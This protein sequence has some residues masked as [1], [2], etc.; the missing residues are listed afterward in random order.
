MLSELGMSASALEEEVYGYLLGRSSTSANDISQGI[1]KG[2]GEILEALLA[3]RDRNLA[4]RIP[5]VAD[6]GD[7]SA[8]GPDEDALWSA[9]P[10]DVALGP[11]VGQMRSDLL[12][13]E[14]ALSSLV[15]AY[16]RRTPATPEFFELWEGRQA[17]AQRLVEL[18]RSA[19]R[20]IWVFQ[21]GGNAVAPVPLT[22]TE[23]RARPLPA[24]PPA[25]DEKDVSEPVT[26][27]SDISYR[28]IVDTAF[29]TEPSAVRALDERLTEGHDVRVVDQQLIKLAIADESLAM[30]QIN[31]NASVTFQEPFVRLATELFHAT[32]RRSRP[33]LR[34][35]TDLSSGDRLVLQLMLSGLTDDAM[36]KQ[37]GTSS[38][39]VQRRLRAM[40]DVAEVSSR[41]QL[42]WYAMRNNW[43]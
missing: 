3:L 18:E 24:P 30:M 15:Q 41:I 6:V 10:P 42:G 17:Q 36:A 26:N 11:S 21:T 20:S 8:T 29:L 13:A 31:A 28:V 37:L 25:L 16:H 33:Y 19:T 35:G 38:R 43:V 12:R 14:T 2:A 27:G 22:F 9:T 4:T 39:T 40:M 5:S 7:D 23:P 32:W 1:G 34:E